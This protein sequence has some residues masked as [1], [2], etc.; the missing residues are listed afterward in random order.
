MV[1]RRQSMKK[2]IAIVFVA[3]AILGVSAAGRAEPTM[4]A[5]RLET[6]SA[7]L[8][9]SETIDPSVCPWLETAP[10]PSSCVSLHVLGK[11]F[12][13]DTPLSFLLVGTL[14]NGAGEL[15]PYSDSSGDYVYSA[16]PAG[17]VNVALKNYWFC[18]RNGDNGSDE[19][20]FLHVEIGG[21]VSNSVALCLF[22]LQLD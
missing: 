2:I 17:V 13:P 21:V 15:L 18:Y 16:N 12:E 9:F 6:T 22:P 7:K 4:T 20:L 14:L 11:G 3:T 19:I 8:N 1:Y 5:A 10:E